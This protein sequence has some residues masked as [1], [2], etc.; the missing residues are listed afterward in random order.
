MLKRAATFAFAI[1]AL[2]AVAVAP[3]AERP[4]II[5]ILADD[6]GYGDL[7]YYGHAT[8][9]TPNLDRIAAEEMRFTDF[10]AAVE[11]CTASQAALLTVRYPLR[12]RLCYDQHLVTRD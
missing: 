9:R 6:L 2:M 7:G 11:V 4:N 12:C 10:Y 8:I 3:A 5:I 1:A